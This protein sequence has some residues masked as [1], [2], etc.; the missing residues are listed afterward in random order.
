[1]KPRQRQEQMLAQLHALQSELTVEDLARKFAVSSLTV[2]RDL[3]QLEADRF[4]YS[5]C[6]PSVRQAS[7]G[8]L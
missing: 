5:H 8:K 2:R 1:M 3:D 6:A 7:A 4:G